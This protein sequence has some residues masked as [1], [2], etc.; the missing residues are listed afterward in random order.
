MKL[1]TVLSAYFCQHYH[2][3]CDGDYQIELIDA[4]K[5]IIAERIDLMAKMKYIEFREKGY[6]LTFVKELY[7]RHIEAFSLGTFSE[8]GNNNKNS[9]QKYFDTFHDLI[10][11]IKQNG[12]DEK[13]SI[14]PVGSNMGII[15]GAHRVAIAAYFNQ[16]L[17]CLRFNTIN[18]VYDAN[19]F[20]KRSL[21]EKYLE[22]LVSEYC[23][24]QENISLVCVLPGTGRKGREQKIL[25]ALKAESRKIVY[26][27][28]F[29]LSKAGLTNLMQLFSSPQWMGK[30]DGHLLPEEKITGPGFS[31]AGSA[32]VYVL[33]GECFKY[34]VQTD[35]NYPTRSPG[36]NPGIYIMNDHAEAIQLALLLLN[37]NSIDFLNTGKQS[38]DH[39]FKKKIDGF[40]KMIADHG[41]S[42]EEFMIGLNG[43][44]ALCGSK[45]DK[46]IGYMTASGNCG[47]IED[48]DSHI[49]H[50]CLDL[51]QSTINDL[52][53][54]PDNY[55]FY[56]G[57]KF[58]T[59]KMA[60]K[61]GAVGKVQE[62]QPDMKLMASLPRIEYSRKRL[63]L[64]KKNW[65]KRKYRIIKNFIK[66][67]FTGLAV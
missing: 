9:I 30:A 12:I 21:D 63:F 36:E 34:G 35:E 22:Y 11:H 38:P 29:E 2:A 49:Q 44:M 62:D 55:F 26:E 31:Q 60:R 24:L 46:E 45:G 1:N 25:A 3:D 42:S 66:M 65:A 16:K 53:F 28:R 56:R 51:D 5:L 20:K 32:V 23:K 40:K 61:Y 59:L 8:L 58:I 54:N 6:N 19:Y 57:M 48:I 64:E 33:E 41:C 52:I 10:D 18:V 7:T 17:P 50:K 37:Q 4:S 13:I 47:L 67:I 39:H 27:K 43:V 15:D 14:I